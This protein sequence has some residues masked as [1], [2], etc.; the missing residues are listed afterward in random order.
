MGRTDDPPDAA[1]AFVEVAASVFA[2]TLEPVSV[3]SR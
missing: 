3:L 1:L 2:Q